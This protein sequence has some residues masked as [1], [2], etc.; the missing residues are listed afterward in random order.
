MKGVTREEDQRMMQI[1]DGGNVQ[2]TQWEVGEHVVFSDVM[3]RQ[4]LKS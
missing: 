2:E 4:S 1:W 3:I